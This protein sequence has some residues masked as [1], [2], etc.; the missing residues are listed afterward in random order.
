[1]PTL[2]NE[3]NKFSRLRWYDDPDCTSNGIYNWSVTNEKLLLEVVEDACAARVGGM[4][5][6]WTSQ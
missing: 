4:S 1:M 6:T 2:A 5:G 3:Q